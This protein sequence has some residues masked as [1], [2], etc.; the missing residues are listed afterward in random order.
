MGS[1]HS[2]GLDTCH[3]IVTSTR[4]R[5]PRTTGDNVV[6]AIESPDR[7]VGAVL[8]RPSQLCMANTQRRQWD[9]EQA[10]YTW[11]CDVGKT[12]HV[13]CRRLRRWDP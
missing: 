2:V 4:H 7:G 9:R 1:E 12:V 13:V 10:T 11:E 8:L 5:V 6:G 3:G